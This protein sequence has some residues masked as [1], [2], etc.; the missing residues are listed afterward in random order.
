MRKKYWFILSGILLVSIATNAQLPIEV[1]II[2][3]SNCD[4]VT[5]NYQDSMTFCADENM[6]LYDPLAETPYKEKVG[7]MVRFPSCVKNVTQEANYSDMNL[8]AAQIG[9][10]PKFINV[11]TYNT[12]CLQAK[13][14]DII[15]VDFKTGSGILIWRNESYSYP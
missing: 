1:P 5:W 10:L 6:L 4:T 12:Q 7:T 13:C 14:R 8:T 15:A 3:C 2:Y 11:T 9:K